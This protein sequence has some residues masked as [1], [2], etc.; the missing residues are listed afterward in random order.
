VS[1]REY[2]HGAEDGGRIYKLYVK[3]DFKGTFTRADGLKACVKH[4]Q[5]GREAKLQRV[6][7]GKADW[8]VC[9]WRDGIQI[10]GS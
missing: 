3:G 9:H 8:T 4:G 5:A 10:E 1:G 7:E 2:K 6:R